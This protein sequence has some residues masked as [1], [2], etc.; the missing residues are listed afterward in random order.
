MPDTI[1]EISDNAFYGVGPYLTDINLPR[2]I[3]RIGNRAFYNC[4]YTSF[5]TL[6]FKL[7]EIGDEAFYSCEFGILRTIFNINYS[8]DEFE[9]TTISGRLLDLPPFL[10]TIGDRAFDNV[11]LEYVLIPKGVTE[12]GTYAFDSYYYDTLYFE[13]TEE[14]VQDLYTNG[15]PTG[16]RSNIRIVE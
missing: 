13:H 5:S 10:K 3:V 6:P 15:T 12:I 8:E 16:Y 14:E 2:G 11:D 4:S 9:G 1:R 7:E